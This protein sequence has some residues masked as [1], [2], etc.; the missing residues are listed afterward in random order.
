MLRLG[1]TLC[2]VVV[3]QDL[4]LPV[5]SHKFV[6]PEPIIAREIFFEQWKALGWVLTGTC[7]VS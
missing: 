6:M 3:A 1:Y 4:R 2:N 7:G 5:A